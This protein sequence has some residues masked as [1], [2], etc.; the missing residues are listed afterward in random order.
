MQGPSVID[1]KMCCIR[2][3]AAQLEDV[4]RLCYTAAQ[5]W[6]ACSGSPV[7]HFSFAKGGGKSP[8]YNPHKALSPEPAIWLVFSK[9]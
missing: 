8:S 9:C 2:P 6:A 1:I 4:Y 3:G 5:L 7:L